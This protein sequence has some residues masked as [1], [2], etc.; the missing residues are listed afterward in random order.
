MKRSQLNLRFQHLIL[1]HL[2][3]Q[4]PTSQSEFIGDASERVNKVDVGQLA[5][6]SLKVIN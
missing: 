4:E 1:F 6:V 5:A 2:Y 3:L